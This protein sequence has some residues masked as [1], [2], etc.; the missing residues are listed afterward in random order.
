MQTDESMY[1]IPNAAALSHL[2]K[3]SLQQPNSEASWL[4]D[5]HICRGCSLP[6]RS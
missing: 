2:T 6:G 5:F 1:V 3:F 4:S